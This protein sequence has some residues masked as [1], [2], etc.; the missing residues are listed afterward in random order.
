MVSGA[1]QGRLLH[2][3]VRLARPARVLEVGCFTGYA[4]LW[5][6]LGLPAGGRLLS[7]ERDERCAEVAVRHLEVAGV[8]G[9]VEV[10]LGDALASLES[11]PADEA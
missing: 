4:A 2:M 6:A 7:L 9:S 5:M 11:L 8:G 1:Q 3:L 10:R